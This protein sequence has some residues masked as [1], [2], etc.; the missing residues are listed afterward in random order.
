VHFAVAFQAVMSADYAI[1][2]FRFLENLVLYHGFWSYARVARLVNYF[3]YK[4][5]AFTLTQTWYASAKRGGVL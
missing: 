2:Q 5:I 3:F 1:A 4:N